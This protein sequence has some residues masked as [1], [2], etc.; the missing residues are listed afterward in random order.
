MTFQEIVLNTPDIATGYMSGLQALEKGHRHKVE[1]D[2]R[3]LLGGSV[4]IDSCTTAKYPNDNRWDYA[5]DYDGKV[6]FVEVH[7]AITSE[8]STV[9]AKFRWL[10]E[11]LRTEAPLL[12]RRKAQDPYHWLQSN[13]F[14][15]PK[16]APQ[17]RAI[18]Q[19]GLKPKPKLIL[20]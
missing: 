3:T 5:I 9:I 20:K 17:L 19:A 10:K 18:V 2:D 7:S 4:D 6:Y 15:I 14:D 1:T 12:D 16:T 11:W 8:V 13:N